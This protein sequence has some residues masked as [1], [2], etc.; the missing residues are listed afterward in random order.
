M[1]EYEGE[2]AVA[3]V[4][5]D[6]TERERAEAEMRIRDSAIASSLNAIALADLEGNLIYVNHSFLK[7]WGYDNDRE[8][9]GKPADYCPLSFR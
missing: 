2:P 7:L 9:L 1:N 6:I 3:A 4:V 8:V 5:R